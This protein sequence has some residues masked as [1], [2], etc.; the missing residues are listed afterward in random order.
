MKALAT[1]TLHHY[2]PFG[3]TCWLSDD[4]RIAG[5]FPIVEAW[6]EQLAASEQS[7]PVPADTFA[8][9]LN[10]SIEDVLAVVSAHQ[11]FTV[12]AGYVFRGNLTRSRIRAVR[13][14]I[15]AGH[16][17]PDAAPLSMYTLWMEYRQ[18]FGDVDA[19]S[20]SDLRIALADSRGA[21]HLFVVD[22]NKSVFA[23]AG[24]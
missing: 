23:L 17:S 21:P 8:A 11:D 24:C 10:A 15:L 16:L 20:S 6:L 12:Y 22:T 13:A 2:A 19:C 5:N 4:Q 18:R 7:L 9:V 3:V 14:H 1:S